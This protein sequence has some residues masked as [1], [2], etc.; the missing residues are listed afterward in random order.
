MCAG[1]A[2]LWPE[3]KG[4]GKGRFFTQFHQYQIEDW[5]YW[6]GVD[7]EIEGG[8]WG[9]IREMFPHSL[10]QCLFNFCHTLGLV[11]CLHS[12]VQ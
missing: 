9:W 1:L 11:L 2:Y 10:C 6:F 5:E 4:C 3:R 7:C 8:G 12:S